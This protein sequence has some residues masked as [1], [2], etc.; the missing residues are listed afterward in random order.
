MPDWKDEIQQRLGSLNIEPTREAAIIEELSQHLDDCYAELLAEGK[1]A[2][3]AVR[4]A[5]AELSDSDLLARELMRVEQQLTRE[6]VVIGTTRRNS[7]IADLWQDLRYG[8]RMLIKKPGFT[9]IGIHGAGVVVDR[10]HL[11]SRSGASDG[12]DGCE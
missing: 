1:N 9:L 3:E 4:L 2:D 11:R 5:W 7:M 8:A 6:P 12:K 10:R